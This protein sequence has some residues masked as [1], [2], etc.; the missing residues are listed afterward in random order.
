M[1]GSV[2]QLFVLG[3]ILMVSVAAFAKEDHPGKPENPGSQ[4]NGHDKDH[5]N[6]DP[7]VAGF[8]IITPLPSSTTGGSMTVFAT[9]GKKNG[10]DVEQAGIV[11]PGLTTSA[12]VFV[13]SSG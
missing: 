12:V 4:G 11:P 6:D 8:A 1:K 2:R 13:S 10:G 9:F 3:L 5:D 7:I